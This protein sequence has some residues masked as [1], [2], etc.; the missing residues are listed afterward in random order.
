MDAV[1]IEVDMDHGY[2]LNINSDEM[3]RNCLARNCQLK[4]LFRFDIIDGEIC[5]LPKVYQSVTNI[6]VSECVIVESYNYYC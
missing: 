6:A 5:P 2:E 4:S 3:C 1:S